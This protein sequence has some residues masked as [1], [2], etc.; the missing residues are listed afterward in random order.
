M[1]EQKSKNESLLIT[2][3]VLL[4]VMLA[5]F[6]EALLPGKVLFSNDSPLGSQIQKAVQLPKA[7][8]GVW[9]DL[10]TLGING[11]TYGID[12]STLAFSLLGPV[13]FAKVYV[14]MV[15]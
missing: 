7:F 1:A 10:N 4:V 12:L 15:L 5:L 13:M 8:T 14:P 3:V 11:G 9:Y 6:G 2:G